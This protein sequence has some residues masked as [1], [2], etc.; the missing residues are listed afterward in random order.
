[1]K[2][3]IFGYFL[4]ALGI[5]GCMPAPTSDELP[6]D[7]AELNQFIQSK[8]DE[9]RTLNQLIKAAE[10]KL[11]ELDPSSMEK[12]KTSVTSMK[13][14]KETFQHFVEIQGNV[15]AEDIVSASSEMGGIIISMNQKEGQYIKRGQL[16]ARLDT[17]TM[18]KQIQELEIS[19][20]LAKTVFE[21]QQRLW[22]QEIGSEIQFLQAKNNKERLEKSLET[23]RSQLKKANVY[24]PISG[25]IDQVFLKTGELAGPG[26]PIVQ[27]LNTAR[28]KVVTAVPE[29]Y[30]GSI[31]RN[32]VVNVNFP[33]LGEETQAKVSLL[34]RT[35]DPANRTFNVEIM[36]PN[37]GGKLKPNLLAEM[38]LMDQSIDD[39]IALPTYLV[40][41]EV[42][43]KQYVMIVNTCEANSCA[44]KA[45]VTT[46][47]TYGG[48]IVIET[49]L[50]GDEEVIVEGARALSPGELIEVIKQS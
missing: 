47:L 48:K 44:T 28:V 2:H 43:G 12:P 4:V 39:A 38:M 9:A 20:D 46:G 23:A 21:K 1:M 50:N 25:V 5:F 26:M 34:G 15:Q 33:A 11:G 10:E 8:K 49:G 22:E 41:Q 31:K 35:I 13:I 45:Y 30:L 29:V 42:G 6:E 18:D 40:Q 7:V 3:H 24:A 19:L 17:E 16:I 36:L 14:E 27:I 32:D 37:R